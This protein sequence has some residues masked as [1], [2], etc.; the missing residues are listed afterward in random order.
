[1]AVLA[2]LG[3]FGLHH[4]IITDSGCAGRLGS[5]VI[6]ADLPDSTHKQRERCLFYH[7]GSCLE[8]VTNCPIDALDETGAINKATCWQRLQTI[9]KQYAHLGIAQVCG[10]CSLGPCALASAV[11]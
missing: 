10:K 8:C 2:G 7:D 5:F 11:G 6:D 1:V 9:A 4:L 3:S